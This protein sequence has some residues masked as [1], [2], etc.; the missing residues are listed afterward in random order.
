M[1]LSGVCQESNSKSQPQANSAQR[2]AQGVRR[3]GRIAA[4]FRCVEFKLFLSNTRHKS[5]FAGVLA[6]NGRLGLLNEVINNFEDIIRSNRGD[7]NFEIVSAEELNANTKKAISD[8]LS[9]GGKKIEVS[10]QTRP[11]ILGGIIVQIGDRRL[12][13]SIASRVKKLTAAIKDSV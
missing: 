7:L 9:K 11:E 8:A 12:D 5:H 3:L 6:E 10:Y 2:R 13:L 4:I 1:L